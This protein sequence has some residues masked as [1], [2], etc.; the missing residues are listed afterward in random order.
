MVGLLK[1][2][3][4]M[5]KH[6]EEVSCYSIVLLYEYATL[7]KLDTSVLFD[8]LAGSKEHLLDRHAWTSMSNWDTFATNF[9][10]AG[11]DLYQAG[12]ET[13]EQQIAFFPATLFAGF[14]FF[15]TPEACPQDLSG[16][17]RTCSHLGS[18]PER[19]RCS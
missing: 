14:P 1:S 19:Q 7:K 15:S 3:A 10:R 2:K 16:N 18:N 4:E 13:A 17:D 11:G 6:T 8:G 9:E 12:I 5:A